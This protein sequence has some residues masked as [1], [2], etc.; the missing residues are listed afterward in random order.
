MVIKELKPNIFHTVMLFSNG[1]TIQQEK[2][3]EEIRELA[4]ALVIG[5]REHIVEELA[6]V[7]IVIPYITKMFMPSDKFKIQD[8][9]G[10]DFEYR[11]ISEVV[12]ALIDFRIKY[13]D[14]K[15]T[16]NLL[17]QATFLLTA[18]LHFIYVK[19]KIERE[20]VEAWKEEKYR[21]CLKNVA[22]KI[23]GG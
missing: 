2:I 19:Y 13:G 20:E 7:E 6:D 16:R 22:K 18:S 15:I 12:V 17:R 9:P 8:V 1:R 23:I 3:R 21:R 11:D 5:D 14:L 4:E 10:I